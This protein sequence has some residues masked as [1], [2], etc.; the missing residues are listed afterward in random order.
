MTARQLRDVATRL[1]PPLAA[2]LDEITR[3]RLDGLIQALWQERRFTALFVTH[4]L[5]EAA[6]LAERAI[7]F[8]RRPARIV[9][10]RPIEFPGERT[11]ELRVVPAYNELVERLYQ[12][13]LTAEAG[14]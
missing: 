11:A 7:M 10:D 5:R 4:S 1:L 13:L 3:Q 12:D 9:T 8:S 2:A 14:A 6:F